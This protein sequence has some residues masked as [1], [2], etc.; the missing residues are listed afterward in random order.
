ME[1][2]NN[3][4]L[5]IDIQ[6]K[7]NNTINHD[8][9]QQLPITFNC[10][11]EKEINEQIES[12]KIERMFIYENAHRHLK[13]ALDHEIGSFNLIQVL[14]DYHTTLKKFDILELSLKTELES[15][16]NEQETSSLTVDSPKQSISNIPNDTSITNTN[17][18]CNTTV[19]SKPVTR[20]VRSVPFIE[21]NSDDSEDDEK[22]DGDDDDYIDDEII[23]IDDNSPPFDSDYSTPPSSPS[24]SPSK[25]VSKSKTRTSMK[26]NF[27]KNV[28]S[29]N[30]TTTT[31]TTTTTAPTKKKRGRPAKITPEFCYVCR[32]TETPYW[33]RGRNGDLIVDLCNA[34]GLHYMKKDKK[35]KIAREKQSINNV[36]NK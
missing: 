20:G 29:T 2:I 18:S 28:P 22:D 4:P 3:F 32:R 15:I 35:E 25:K 12:I 26:R 10:N 24:S 27:T 30:S 31:T 7:I 19:I 34:C 21:I 16:T 9:Q 8:P 5:S 6:S 17:S 13:I 23:D 36:L 14:I 1:N 11:R 33:R